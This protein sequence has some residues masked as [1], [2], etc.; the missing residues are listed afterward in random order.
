MPGFGARR[1][2]S[3][4]R[5]IRASQPRTGDWISRAINNSLLGIAGEDVDVDQHRRGRAAI[6]RTSG[7]KHRGRQRG[8]LRKAIP[9]ETQGSIS[10]S[11]IR[12]EIPETIPRVSDA[13]NH[14][15]MVAQGGTAGPRRQANPAGRTGDSADNNSARASRAGE[16]LSSRSSAHPVAPPKANGRPGVME[17]SACRKR[18]PSSDRDDRCAGRDGTKKHQTASSRFVIL[19]NGPAGKAA[20]VETSPGTSCRQPTP[21]ETVRVSPQPDRSARIA[22]A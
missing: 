22:S 15:R 4:T 17:A 7:N 5:R 9:G 11:E 18:M 6:S 20:P 8:R 2:G 12:A 16:G 3:W 13:S 1:T 19:I 10:D 21:R 14:P